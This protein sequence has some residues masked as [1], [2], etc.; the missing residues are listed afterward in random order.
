LVLVGW[1]AAIALQTRAFL[2]EAFEPE[3][4]NWHGRIDLLFPGELA[5]L[6][7]KLHQPILADE[8]MA[9][10]RRLS[11][12]ECFLIEASSFREL[13]AWGRGFASPARFGARR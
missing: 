4:L 1:P 11:T 2:G 5:S 7:P 9:W 3:M 6:H 12:I 8:A 13:E 10:Q